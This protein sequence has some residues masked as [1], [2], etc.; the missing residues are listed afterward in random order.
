MT[1]QGKRISVIALVALALASLS[2]AG[3]ISGEL[4]TW[5]K[6]TLTFD[7]PATSESADPNPFLSYRL[8]VT[9][10]HANG[11][12]K[13]L[14]PGFYAADGNAA[15]TS[16]DSGN[17]WRVHFAPDRTGTWS[18]RVSFRRG[19]NV[20]VSNDVNAGTSAGYMDGRTGSFRIAPTDKT[21]R[22]LRGKGRLQYVG[23]HYLR[24]AGTGDYFLKAGADAPENF[25][26]YADF[27]GDFKTDGHKDEFIKTWEPHIRDW[28]PGDPTW[29]D[30]KG[31]GII[32]AINYLASK[33]MNSVYFLTYNLDGGDGKDVWMWTDPE[34]RLHFDCSKLD[35]WEIVFS[36]MDRLGLMLHV[37]TQ[38]TEN[39][40]ALDGGELGRRRKLYYRELIARFEVEEREISRQRRILHAKID[41]LRAELVMRLQRERQQGRSIISATDVDRL[42]QILAGKGPFLDSDQRGVDSEGPED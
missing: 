2:P 35:Q 26:A 23:G 14:V 36:H 41:I 13:Y 27:D 3:Q 6:V 18:Y 38:E 39:D 30:G 37:V 28:K 5:H 12:R 17:K 8:N 42:S 11:G 1:T 7:G 9:F 22:D 32:G 33:G 15:N 21:G 29:Q 19:E 24:F 16:A 4:K 25:L 34:A 10:E 31:K 40:Q 20:A